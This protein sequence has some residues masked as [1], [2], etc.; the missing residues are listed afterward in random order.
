MLIAQ[1]IGEYASMSGLSAAFQSAYYQLELLIAGLS[2]KEYFF[3]AVAGVVLFR[4]F[5]KVR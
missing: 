5:S 4:V 2:A 3:I 1:G